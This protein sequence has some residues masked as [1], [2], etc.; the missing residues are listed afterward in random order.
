MT[1]ILAYCRKVE[2]RNELSLDL[3]K[4]DAANIPNLLRFH[5]KQLANIP[6]KISTWLLSLSIHL[7]GPSDLP[8]MCAAIDYLLVIVG[9]DDGSFKMGQKR[10]KVLFYQII[11]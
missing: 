5:L 1:T 2:S 3:R 8:D 7:S 9:I 11:C 10:R 4:Q 6:C